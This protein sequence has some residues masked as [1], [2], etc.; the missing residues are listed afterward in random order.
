MDVDFETALKAISL[1]TAVLNLAA[2]LL[3]YKANSKK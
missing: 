1:A 3:I 2:A